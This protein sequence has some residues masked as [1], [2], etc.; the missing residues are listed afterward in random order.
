MLCSNHGEP[1]ET[2]S[3]E[4]PGAKEGDGGMGEMREKGSVGGMGRKEGWGGVGG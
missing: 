4:V 2:K 3:E 1:Q